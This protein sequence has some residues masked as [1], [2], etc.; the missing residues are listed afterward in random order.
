MPSSDGTGLTPRQ[1]VLLAT[2]MQSA[3]N[4]LR[5][6]RNTLRDMKYA[7]LAEDS[8]YTLLSLGVEKLLKLSI[9]LASVEEVGEWPAKRVRDFSHSIID[10]DDAV[11]SL[12]SMNIGRSTH[13]GYTDRALAALEGDLVWPLLRNG[14]ENYGSGGRYHYLDWISKEPRYDSPRGYWQS[15]ESE[16]LRQ[17]PDLYALFASPRPGDSEAARQRTNEVIA[18][19]LNLW[20]SAIHTFWVQGVFGSDA[21]MMSSEI[22]PKRFSA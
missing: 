18:A 9:G 7:S 16:V 10:L 19:S 20:W 14:L 3:T 13:R 1:G 4:L 6:G 17:Q 21:R 15:V 5:D 11:R 12:M 8:V 22:D 2:E